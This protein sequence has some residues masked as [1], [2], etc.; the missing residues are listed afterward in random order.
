MPDRVTRD[1][2]EEL[3][4]T[5]SAVAAADQNQYDHHPE[6]RTLPFLNHARHHVP[7]LHRGLVI[8]TPSPSSTSLS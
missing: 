6:S 3:C 5:H 7:G 1:A 4:D 2:P 8:K